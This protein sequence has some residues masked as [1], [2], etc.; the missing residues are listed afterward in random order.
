[1]PQGHSMEFAPPLPNEKED[2]VMNEKITMLQNE[3]AAIA[4]ENV[5]LKQ[6]V[7]AYEQE[8]QQL[9]DTVELLVAANL[10]ILRQQKSKTHPR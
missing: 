6:R 7:A 5:V 1:M 3:N 10:T 8:I 9:K 2:A 4:C